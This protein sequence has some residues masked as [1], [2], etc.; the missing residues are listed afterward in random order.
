MKTVYLRLI[1]PVLILALLLPNASAQDY[2]KWKLPAGAKMRIG[3]G[4]IKDLKFS[5]D[6]TR[7]AIAGSI[8]IWI[9]DVGT[10][11]ELDLLTGHTDR[12][13]SVSFSPDG[14]TLASGSSDDTI[15]LWDVSTGELLK[16]LTGQKGDVMSVS[17]SPDG[18]MLASGDYHKTV[19][20]WDAITGE[21]LK[22]LTGHTFCVSIVSVF[23]QTA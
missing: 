2:N 1:I 9:H 11:R 19:R 8:G 12:V 16:T 3:K 21:L 10:G 14:M 17:F 7:L 18:K 22:T 23:R 20:L 5:P 13:E 4:R 6:G 15:R